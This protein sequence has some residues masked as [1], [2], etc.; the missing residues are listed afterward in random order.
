MSL[1]TLLNALT[2]TK[3]LIIISAS[4]I[5]F[6]NEV[7]LTNTANALEDAFIKESEI[8]RQEQHLRDQRHHEADRKALEEL[9]DQLKHE[10]GLIPDYDLIEENTNEAMKRG[11]EK[12]M[13]YIDMRIRAEKA[14]FHLP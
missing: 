10:S 2:S 1:N 4:A 5:T 8:Q 6:V 3:S 12:A 7:R 9:V 13:A 14:D 11:A